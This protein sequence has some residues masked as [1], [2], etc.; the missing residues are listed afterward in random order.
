MEWADNW[1]CTCDEDSDDL[2]MYCPY[3]TPVDAPVCVRGVRWDMP[4]AMGGTFQCHASVCVVGLLCPV[5][6]L[7]ARLT[8]DSG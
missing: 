4:Q 5:S 7:P 3:D 6:G 2:S 8:L 1:Y